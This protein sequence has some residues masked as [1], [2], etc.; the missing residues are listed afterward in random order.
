MGLMLRVLKHGESGPG[1]HVLRKA[2][3]RQPHKRYMLRVSSVVLSHR[4]WIYRRLACSFESFGLRLVPEGA[5]A[6]ASGAS[7]TCTGPSCCSCCSSCSSSSCRKPSAAACFVSS[8]AFAEAM[9][10]IPANAKGSSLGTFRRLCR[11]KRGFGSDDL[12]G[13]RH[14]IRSDDSA[15]I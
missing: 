12:F 3:L 4:W 5:G 11:S 10:R 9:S 15:S 6:S 2:H 8:R 7:G 1:L 13:A 14:R